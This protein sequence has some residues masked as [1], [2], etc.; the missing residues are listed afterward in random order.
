MS[1][2]K[3]PRCLD[4]GENVRGAL[5]WHDIAMALNEVSRTMLKELDLQDPPLPKLSS[6]PSSYGPYRSYR[7]TIVRAYVYQDSL[8]LNDIRRSVCI[9]VYR[10][11]ALRHRR[12][13]GRLRRRRL[14]DDL[15]R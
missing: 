8:L 11:E 6:P 1:Y 15:M 3:L 2:L 14:N 5:A 4:G 12:R 7:T 9:Y 10:L 13:A